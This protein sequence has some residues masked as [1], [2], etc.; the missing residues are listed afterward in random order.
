MRWFKICAMVNHGL[1]ATMHWASRTKDS[2]SN[3]YHEVLSQVSMKRVS[4]EL[5]RGCAG[6]E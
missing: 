3:D 2:G 6:N 1:G 4:L 5:I